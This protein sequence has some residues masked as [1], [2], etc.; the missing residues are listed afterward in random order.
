MRGGS[1]T[2]GCTYP[3]SVVGAD[4][5]RLEGGQGKAEAT[6]EAAE[7]VLTVSDSESEVDTPDG[8]ASGTGEEASRGASGSSGAGQRTNSIG[9][10]PKASTM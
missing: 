8:T 1:K 10:G 4:G 5:D 9:R 3:K 2:A 7:P 6:E